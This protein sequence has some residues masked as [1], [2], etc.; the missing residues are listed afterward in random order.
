[1]NGSIKPLQNFALAALTLVAPLSASA[2][3]TAPAT[4]ARLVEGKGAAPDFLSESAVVGT[5]SSGA[6][7]AANGSPTVRVASIKK[8]TTPLEAAGVYAYGLADLSLRTVFT[9]GSGRF[10][11]DALPA[12]I[13][14]IIAHKP[15]F[16]PAVV[17]LTRANA[18]LY[19]ELELALVPEDAL[20]ANGPQDFWK[21]R[22]RIPTDVL[23]A[24]TIANAP[25]PETSPY[26]VDQPAFQTE[27]RALHGVGDYDSAS[28]AEV[29][30]G[31]LD[32]KGRLGEMEIALAGYFKQ[33]RSSAGL[34]HST[35]GQSQT[36]AF[37]I[38]QDTGSRIRV[39]SHQS[40][41]DGDDRSP[42]DLERYHV[43]WNGD[44]G[45]GRSE[46]S[47]FY[48]EEFNYY[49]D[50]RFTGMGTGTPQSAGSRTL[51]IDGSYER[52]L[53][54]RTSL[55]TGLSYRGRSAMERSPLDHAFA[56][57]STRSESSQ[58]LN[59][60]GASDRFEAFGLG[61]INL[62]S[63][64][65]VQYGM[66]TTLADG[67]LAFTPHAGLVIG[68]GSNWSATAA[69]RERLTEENDPWH[70]DFV[71][72]LYAE[73]SECTNA[74]AR[75]YQLSFERQSDRGTRFSI[76]SM[77]REFS[78]MMRVYFS[79][80]FFDQLDSLLFVQGDRLPEINMSIQR[81]L[82]PS[83]ST[84]FESSLAMGG[85]GTFTRAGK[86]YEND[87]RYVV[88]TLDT[89]F[90]ATSTGVLLSFHSMEQRLN[91]PLR[92]DHSIGGLD[93]ERLQLMV[94][95]GLRPWIGLGSEW[96]LKLDM[97]V[98][99]GQNNDLVAERDG[100]QKRVV[101]GLVVRF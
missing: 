95:Q 30:G 99:R 2:A 26:D 50:P 40:S 38:A 97:Q 25:P 10:S 24:I 75:C 13:Y 77:Y 46:V 11:F 88:S 44:I 92:A 31:Q 12:G 6:S 79:E 37:S 60:L 100:L 85:G 39:S 18:N 81:Q 83:I 61:D 48:V 52:S 93:R 76:G 71:P 17:K 35:L 84:R 82:S 1:M 91:D 68:L 101:G 28:S 19:Q 53:G 63:S 42:V 98:S 21:I 32:L 7:G 29:H 15:G 45:A 3:A 70:A 69:F 74:E 78:D 59:L 47:A 73:S 86:S 27:M 5:V 33:L 96:D 62:A 16:L 43:Q 89:Q 80:D 49:R 55:A 67:S 66:F 51:K 90:D 65:V 34:D 22:E 36:V 14:K 56:A 54:S 57:A 87:V 72:L 9:D 41:L 20:Q 64:V 4:G 23:R 94:T 58:H 8:R